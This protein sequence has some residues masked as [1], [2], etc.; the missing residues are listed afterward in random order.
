MTG[1]GSIG[2]EPLLAWMV[3]LFFFPVNIWGRTI[4]KVKISDVR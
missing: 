3:E 2:L 1:G 4:Y